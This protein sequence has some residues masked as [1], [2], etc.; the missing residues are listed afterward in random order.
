MKGCCFNCGLPQH[1]GVPS[2]NLT[3][4]HTHV[5]VHTHTHAY[6]HIYT[7]IHTCGA[8][9]SS[10]LLAFATS[11]WKCSYLCVRPRATVT[12]TSVGPQQS[13]SLHPLNPPA[14][15]PYWCTVR[16]ASVIQILYAVAMSK[17]RLH[18][19]AWV[20]YITV[21]GAVSSLFTYGLRCCFVLFIAAA[22]CTEFAAVLAGHG[23]ICRV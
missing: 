15:A 10:A 23:G 21:E 4:T 16:V 8:A 22:I 2:L 6:T 17:R 5:H 11:N 20:T 18:A 9:R 1:R 12:C 7:H 3:H 19:A 14:L 13:M